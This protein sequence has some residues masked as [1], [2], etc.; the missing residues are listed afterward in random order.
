MLFRSNLFIISNIH[1]RAKFTNIKQG[2]VHSHAKFT[3]HKTRQ[4]KFK[5]ELNKTDK[6]KKGEEEEERANKTKKKQS[7]PLPCRK[8]KNKKEKQQPPPLPCRFRLCHGLNRPFR[9]IRP[10]SARFSA[11]RAEFEQRR[12]KSAKK[13]KKRHMA[14]RSRTRG[15][16]RRSRVTVSGHV[17]RGYGSS[18][19][20]S[21]LS[22]LYHES[23]RSEHYFPC[24]VSV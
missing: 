21:V 6:T 20:V 18:R 19:A 11:N 12:R 9:L 17:G 2:K 14:G 13:K 24:F 10:E 16:W 8:K 1:S 5:I 15:Q 3:K 22:K 23:E 4:G 7:P